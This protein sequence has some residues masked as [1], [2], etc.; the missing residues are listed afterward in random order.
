MAGPEDA[1]SIYSDIRLRL[2]SLNG[3]IASVK[4]GFD[5]LD[6]YL[7]TNTKKIQGSVENLTKAYKLGAVNQ[8]TYIKRAIALREQELLKIQNSVVK[9]G[10][11]TKEELAQIKSVESELTKLGKEQD[12]LKTNSDKNF[13]AI[14]AVGVAAMVAITVAFKAAIKTFA[15]TEQQLANVR[16]VSD[17]TAKEFEALETAANNAGVT[18]R[19]T[20]SE[21]A[22]ALFYLASAGLEATESV[23]ALDGVLLLAGAT[24][25][26]LAESAQAIT[27]TLSQYGLEAS[28]AADVS[29]I[30]AAAN[31]NSQATLDKLA[32]ALQQVGPIAAGLGIG[33]EETVGSLEALFN[34]GYKGETA[35]RALKSALADLANE[36]SETIKKLDILGVSFSD[37]DPTVVG[38]TGAIGALEEA[39][40]TTSQTIDVFG[41]VAGG[42]LAT[43]IGTG[44]AA[45]E[46]YTKAVTDTDEAAR[47]Y[48]IQND[49]LSGS[50][51]AFKSALEGTSNSLIS[52]LTP[53]FRTIIDLGTGFLKLIN[54]IPDVLKGVSAGATTAAV[55]VGVV[56]KALGLLGVTLSVGPLAVVTLVAGLGVGL[57]VLVKKAGEVRQAKLADEFGAIAEELGYAGTAV[58]EFI[59]KAGKI[60]AA[61]RSVA[62]DLPATF[63]RTNDLVDEMSEKLGLSKDEVVS[64][65]LNAD[66][67][68]S[69][70]K[71]QLTTIKNQIIQQEDLQA[72]IVAQVS[73]EEAIEL[74]KLNQQ[75]L[76]AKTAKEKALTEE[77][78]VARQLRLKEIYKEVTTLDDLANK[79]AISEIDLLE[80][81]KA[82][83]EEEISL[84]I[85]QQL[86]A[87]EVSDSAI[88]DI[89]AQQKKID[90]YDAR[91]QVLADNEK[92]RGEEKEK[93][94]K[95]TELGY[96]DSL[97]NAEFAHRAFTEESEELNNEEEQS[98]QDSAS[99]IAGVATNLYSTLANARIDAINGEIAD[100]ERLTDARLDAIDVETEALLEARGLQEETTLE[101]LQNQLD[102]VNGTTQTELEI[103]D[104]ATQKKLADLGLLEDTTLQ[105]LQKELDAAIL[106]GDTE[107]AAEL[108][109]ELARE[110]ILQDA[111]DAADVIEKAATAKALEDEIARTKI[112]EDAE[113]E[114]AAIE[115][116]AAKDTAKLQYKAEIAGWESS[117]ISTAI[118]GAQ[119]AI[120]AYGA[121]AG[122]PIFGP[123]LGIAA[124]SAV[125]VATVAQLAVI[126]KNK[127]V[128]QT[129]ATG[130]IVLPEAGVSSTGDNI[131]I[132]VNPGEAVF[133]K[134]QQSRLLSLANGGGSSNS[135]STMIQLFMDSKVVAQGVA[136]NFNNGIV[137]V[138]LK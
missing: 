132:G 127:P 57:S 117:K 91:L 95:A 66:K 59:K 77:A 137:K 49:T 50:Q 103:L 17:S 100:I 51:D 80:Q 124:A 44:Q 34:A 68:S 7:A 2:D 129:F 138:V 1:G 115:L 78:S 82:L 25:S 8:E 131:R 112:L 4:A 107:T 84:L 108:E 113:A 134:E 47:Q 33:L 109:D 136:R 92:E 86:T 123:E 89:N 35:G 21:A 72:L 61:F 15:D 32:N 118:A 99:A 97:Q 9:K 58:D 87:G 12:E 128:E 42:Q 13:N 39:G 40:I 121:L 63:K 94:Y 53:T 106:A 85:Q 64:I 70:Y 54:K 104:A 18:T 26:G 23:E 130:G 122:I 3:D 29:N 135:G 46:D 102:A 74:S 27:A 116:Q 98:W 16:A 133:T 6:G 96:E 101:S 62:T 73:R 110:T 83:R 71:A 56:A 120:S 48:A 28:K 69:E 111:A 30:F 37:V 81:K 31:S 41:K 114:K 36:S 43:L 79:G 22:D 10:T 24:G 105:T 75:R 119:A 14:K 60:E 88:A 19:F 11:A 125:G 126:N 38:L 5:K 67:I 55:G 90:E 76:E 20:A 52:T 65:A 93:V 45:L